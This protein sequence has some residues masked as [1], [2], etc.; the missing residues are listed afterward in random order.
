[1]SASLAKK[2]AAYAEGHDTKKE[3]SFPK[4]AAVAGSGCG[5]NGTGGCSTCA[6]PGLQ[7]RKRE[8]LM[9]LVEAA[10]SLAADFT[11]PVKPYAD[12]QADARCMVPV[13]GEATIAGGATTDVIVQPSKGC[14]EGFY[15]DIFAV[16]AANPQSPQRVRV[17]RMFVSD[18][19]QDCRTISM[20]SDFFSSQNTGCC[21]G[22]A[23]RASFG[24]EPNAENLHVE[25]TNP[26]AAG[27]VLVQVVVWGYCVK[28]PCACT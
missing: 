25:I 4:L 2:V 8:P 13:V 1:M 18:C 10:D 6:P 9:A 22:K 21:L 15:I 11:A 19:P 23:L 7:V 26:N 27:S 20:F 24:R 14:F 3:E 12:V 5:C 16:D 17:H 28:S